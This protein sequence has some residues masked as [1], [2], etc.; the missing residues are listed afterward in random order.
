MY[1]IFYTTQIYHHLIESLH[2]LTFAYLI[3]FT[4]FM[5]DA[6]SMSLFYIIKSIT[7]RFS[8]TYNKG[9]Y[10]EEENERI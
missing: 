2:G 8:T 10:E 3:V 1:S 9:F 6:F 4:V 7:G 5:T